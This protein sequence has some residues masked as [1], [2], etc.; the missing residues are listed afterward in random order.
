[1]TKK[2]SRSQYKAIKKL[3][4]S[5]KMSDRPMKFPTYALGACNQAAKYSIEIV[6]ILK[7]FLDDV[8]MKPEQQIKKA[9][10]AIALAKE[11]SRL[12]ERFGASTMPVIDS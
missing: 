3:L 5:L 1:M 4:R 11:Q 6:D 9:A 12:L 7:P 8:D 2:L 10:R